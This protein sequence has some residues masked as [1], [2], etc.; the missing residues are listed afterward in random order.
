MSSSSTTGRDSVP[1]KDLS[2]LVTSCDR[3]SD[4]WPLFFK[5]FAKHWPDCPV[6]VYLGTNHLPAP[7]PSVRTIAVGDDRSWAENIAA[8]LAAIPTP[9]VM[10]FLDD[11]FLL[12]RVDTR[13]LGEL[14][15][16]F[17]GV[18]GGYLRLDPSPPPDTAS[19]L[20]GVG[21]IAPDSPYRSSMHVA[22][23]R[24]DVLLRLL[25]PGESA[26]AMELVGSGRSGAFPERFFSA[27][28]PEIVYDMEGIVRGTWTRGAY[29]LSR[30]ENVPLDLVRRPLQTRA[31]SLRRKLGQLRDALLEIIPWR[32][33]R[34]LVMARLRRHAS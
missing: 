10:I 6:P 29:A 25:R 16:A 21:E 27:W 30:A 5:L 1:W 20:P 9:Y 23:W 32:F 33:R 2:V 18:N 31:Q 4:A 34:R 3:Y 8:M 12:Q 14:L 7:I 24:K 17:R 13:R 15:T 11:H 19:E 28:Q 26:W 22:F